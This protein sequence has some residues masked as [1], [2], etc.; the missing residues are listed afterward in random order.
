MTLALE[1]SGIGKRFGRTEVLSGFDIEVCAGEFIVVIG[2]SGSGKTTFLRS[3]AGLERLDSGILKINGT[4]VDNRIENVFLPPEK[5][6]IGMVFQNYAL[7]P[8]LSATDN[9]SIVI[10]KKNRIQA[11]TEARQWLRVVRLEKHVRAYP[12]ELSGGQQQRVGIARAL[13]TRPRVLLLDEPLSSLDIEIRDSLRT[14]IRRIVKRENVTALYVTHDPA[15]A[16][17]LADKIAVLENGKL[18]QYGTPQALFAEPRTALVAKFT[19]AQEVA[20]GRWRGNRFC[21]G[22]N[23]FLESEIGTRREH[24]S[25]RLYVRPEGVRITGESNKIKGKILHTAFEAGKYRCYWNI[26]GFDYPLVN[27]EN[28]PPPSTANLEIDP[29]HAFIFEA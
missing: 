6:D 24:E 18:I 20:R 22:E 16:W 11:G 17:T 19:G 25:G 29:M 3:I 28:S 9:V 27:Y 14:E 4:V 2:A 12:R 26:E 1:A 5:R 8:H 10:N 21:V 15:D 23:V 13:A 7:W